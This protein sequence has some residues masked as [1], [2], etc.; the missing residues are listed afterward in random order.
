VLNPVRSVPNST[1]RILTSESFGRLFDVNTNAGFRVGRETGLLEWHSRGQGFESPRLHYTIQRL[2]GRGSRGCRQSGLGILAH[3]RRWTRRGRLAGQYAAETVLS[4]QLRSIFHPHDF[5]G[6][7]TH[8]SC[9][10]GVSS[11]YGVLALEGLRCEDCGQVEGTSQFEE[12]VR[13]RFQP[14]E[15]P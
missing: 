11:L 9:I 2:S 1:W 6:T 12:W 10:L 14:K 13:R 15:D 4:C 7:L 8:R 5:S 3:A